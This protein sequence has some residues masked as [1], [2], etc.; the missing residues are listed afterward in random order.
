M[1]KQV[2]IVRHGKSSWANFT[3]SDHDRPLDERGIKDS[4]F[5]ANWLSELGFFPQR[6]ITS[7]AVRAKST[8]RF[9]SDKFGITPDEDRNLYHG[10]PQNYLDQ[11]NLLDEKINTVALFGHNPGIT[12]IANQIKPGCT[13]N[14]PTCGIIIA[15]MEI[16]IPWHKITFEDMELKTILVPKNYVP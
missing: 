5:M 6:L 9:F 4:P 1:Y 13:D 3:I 11:I 2:I 15:T 12:I 14:I 8:A 7:T 16:Q 10:L